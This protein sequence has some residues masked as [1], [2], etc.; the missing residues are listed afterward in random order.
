M[1]I[2]LVRTVLRV[3]GRM[4]SILSLNFRYFDTSM[5]VAENEFLDTFLF[6]LCIACGAVSF[7]SCGALFQKWAGLAVNGVHGL[8]EIV[9]D[10]SSMGT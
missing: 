5:P 3:C 4:P 1:C 6:I 8:E 7:G 10:I 9:I 2:L